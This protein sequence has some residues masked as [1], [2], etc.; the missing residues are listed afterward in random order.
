MPDREWQI[1]LVGTFDVENLGDLLF[2]MIAE[3]EL[4]ERLG[5]VRLH[6]FSY[7]AKASAE[8]PFPVTS[9]TEL[10]RLA[11]DLDG[12]LAGGGFLV[13]FDKEVA[14]GY[15]PPTPAIHHPTG[16]W[17]SPALIALQHGVPLFWNAPGVDYAGLPAWAEPLLELA[18]S[19]SSYVAVRDE[20]SRAALA[21]FADP[22]RIA[23]V[24]DTGFGV[25]RLLG[26]RPSFELGRL[27]EAAGLTGPYI[28]VQPVRG[29]GPFFGFLRRHAARLR[30]YRFLVLPIGPVNGDCAAATEADLAGLVRLPAWPPP[31]L[32]AE[33]IRH[34]AAVV[35]PSYHLAITAMTAGVPVFSPADLSAGKF[36]GLAG[37]PGIHPLPDTEDA[38]P[39]CFVARLGRTAVAPEVGAA[40][41]RLAAHWDCI[42]CGLR[43]GPTATPAAVGRFWQSLPG[44]LEGEAARRDTAVTALAA[45]E[46]ELAAQGEVMAAQGEARA[47][48]AGERA[49]DRERIAE[50]SRL[51]AMARAEIMTRDHRIA[52]LLE[53]TSWKITAPFRFVG[54]R[55]GR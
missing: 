40:L 50:L 39:G 11:A 53:S 12:L 27:R 17:L 47:A 9:V 15:G 30:D 23:V 42:S 26:E 36:P 46:A 43:A 54:R 21:R 52:A 24:P 8:W 19:L 1:G 55:L 31:L 4:V 28:V 13:R 33:L 37:F 22:Q 34:A 41:D 18:F 20:P 7:H 45:A 5:R 29:L 2:P 16:Y 48:L 25:G 10:P 14:P 6:R 38:D 32:L 44:L 51:L 3:A 35:G 49:A